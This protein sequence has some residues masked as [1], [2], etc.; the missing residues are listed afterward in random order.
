MNGR[1]KEI[2]QFLSSETNY[3]KEVEKDIE[4]E[5]ENLLEKNI[6]DL[7]GKE[8]EEMRDKLF[9]ITSF[10]EETGFIKGFQY[11]VELMSECYTAKKLL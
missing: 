5:V 1:I 6:L 2:Y 11:A 8:Y 9:S 4:E 7:N 10:A 3:L